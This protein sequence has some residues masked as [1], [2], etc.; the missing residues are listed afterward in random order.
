M[1]A[2]DF[3][4]FHRA[5]ACLAGKIGPLRVSWD[6]HHGGVQTIRTTRG[7]GPLRIATRLRVTKDDRSM[8]LRQEA[9]P[10]PRLVICEEGPERIALRAMYSLVDPAG[11][12]HGDGLTDTIVYA[13]GQVQLVFGLR[14]VDRTAHDKVS[15]AWVDV[16]AGGDVSAVHLGTRNAR[17]L[18]AD[19]LAAGQTYR[20]GRGLPGRSVVLESPRGAAAFGWYSD[21]GKET[22]NLG[23]VG[24]WHGPGDRSPY[25]DTW[26]HLYDQWRGSAGWSAHPTGRLALGS[27]REGAALCWHWLRGAT[28]PCGEK[29]GL[30]ALISLFFAAD[31][32]TGKQRVASMQRPVVPRANGAEF[33]CLDVVED[34]LLYRKTEKEMSLTFPRDREARRARVRVFGLEGRGAVVIET[35]GKRL[36]PQLLS[37]G[38]MTDDPY[39]PNLARPGDRFAPLIGDLNKGPCHAVFSVPLSARGKTVVTVREAPGINLAYA[40]WDDR[41]TYVIRSSALPHVPMAAFS[42]RTVCLHDLRGAAGREPALIRVPLYWYPTNVQTRGECTNELRRLRVGANGPEALSLE[43]TSTDPNRRA[44]ATVGIDLPTP[45]RAVLVR[46]RTRLH[47]LKPLDLPAIQYLNSFPSNS[48]QPEDWPDDW[49]VLLT[50][51]GRKMCEPFKEPRDKRKKWDHI[52]TWKGRLVFVQGAADRGNIFILAENRKPARQLNGY[53]L[54]PVWLDSHFTFEGLKAPVKP[55]TSFETRYTIGIY[56]DR[57][58]CRASAVELGKLALKNGRLPF[59]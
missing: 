36:T 20:F 15:D 16:E 29:F 43:V 13:D 18:Q 19:E 35:N 6:R 31:V 33:R 40:K 46:V 34:A 59:A 54:C 12:Y 8:L 10:D 21:D 37:L 9:D 56:G 7:A 58:L 55:G 32:R 2:V 30:R 28:E 39:G 53:M 26:G 25:Y 23:G 4:F 52:R 38:G 11:R 49:V 57:G 41:Q 17:V 45:R 47:V 24:L 14:L 44:R 1:S 5:G 22:D 48:W 50:T 42:T 51:D 27:S 3:G